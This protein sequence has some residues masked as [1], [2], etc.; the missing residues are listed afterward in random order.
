MVEVRMFVFNK[1]WDNRE[2]SLNKV[3]PVIED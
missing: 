1:S 2:G 3:M